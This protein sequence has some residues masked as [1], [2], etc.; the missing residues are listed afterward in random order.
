MFV[1]KNSVAPGPLGGLSF[2]YFLFF[3]FLF[4]FFCFLF[5]YFWCELALAAKHPY[6]VIV[7]AVFA[8]FVVAHA[9]F[10]KIL[11]HSNQMS[12]VFFSHIA[13]IIQRIQI[14]N[15]KIIVTAFALLARAF[16]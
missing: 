4:L 10:P 6:S 15:S 9:R 2:L 12:S 5:F 11:R 1:E 13:L 7:V 16:D 14:I 3:L 8:V